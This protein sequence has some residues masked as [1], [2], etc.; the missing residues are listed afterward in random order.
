MP[1]SVP[2]RAMAVTTVLY[3]M[4]AAGSAEA[5]AAAIAKA[6]KI[7]SWFVMYLRVP[8]SCPF[9]TSASISGQA[10]ALAKRLEAATGRL[11]NSSPIWSALAI[12]GFR[13]SPPI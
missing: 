6:R 8:I 9:G 12:I 13:G 11:C 1:K 2:L 7:S 10:I 4:P 5:L 3:S